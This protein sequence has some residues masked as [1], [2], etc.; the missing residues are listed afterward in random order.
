M[1][2]IGYILWFG[3]EPREALY[4][5]RLRTS[6]VIIRLSAG[7]ALVEDA[8]IRNCGPFDQNASEQHC[9][10]FH[11]RAAQGPVITY[12]IQESSAGAC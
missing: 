10:C 6:I 8:K 9:A 7:S 2:T 11:S 5:V 3:S 12:R 4:D 1:L